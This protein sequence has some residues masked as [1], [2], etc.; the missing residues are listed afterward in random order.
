[1]SFGGDGLAGAVA[2]ALRGRRRRPRRPARR[3][4]QRLRPHAR[5]SPAS[6]SRRATSSSTAASARSTSPRS[7]AARSSASPAT[8]STPTCRTSPTPPRSS[9]GQLVYLY[10][11]LRALAALEAR[12]AALR[13]RRRGRARGRAATRSPRATPA[14]SAAGC[15]SRPTRA[16]RTACS[17]SSSPAT[18]RSCKCLRNLPKLFK[19]THLDEPEVELFRAAELR[20][21]AE[22]PFRIYADGDPIG[23]TPATIR[24]VPQA[25]RVLVPA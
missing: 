22:R 16:S 6:R 3:P 7:T 1:M 5:R 24:A 18:R 21:D 10:A 15:C 14:C 13:G 23:T 4:R 8:A 25:L 17:T 19:G 2:H 12:P 9:S 11:T 20:V